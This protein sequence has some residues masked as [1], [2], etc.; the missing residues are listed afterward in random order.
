MNET[1]EE[2]YK[3]GSKA[4]YPQSLMMDMSRSYM[5]RQDRIN[6]LN[7]YIQKSSYNP[8][9][10]QD[11]EEEEDES[12][13]ETL[14]DIILRIL[15][16]IYPD[17][18]PGLWFII[19]FIMNLIVLCVSL[20]S[21]SEPNLHDPIAEP[22]YNRT[23]IYGSIYCSF[24]ILGVNIASFTLIMVIH[25]IIQK[26]FLEKLLQPSALCA[27]FYNTV[28]PELVYLLW[29][30]VQIIYWRSNMI[31]K[32]GV[33]ENEN[34]F[35]LR[36]FGYKDQDNPFIFLSSINWLI[37]FPTLLYIVF[38]ARLLFLSIISFVFEL[39]FLMNAHDLLGKYLS[40]YGI[41]RKFNIEWFM[42][43]ADKQENIRSLFGYELYQDEK[44]I[45]QL[46]TNDISKKFVQDKAE[47]LL[48]KNLP[49]NC[50]CCK[51]A[52]NRNKKKNAM[53]L[54]VPPIFETKNIVKTENSTIKNWL[55]CHYVVNTPP[56]IFLLNNSIPL[57]NKNSVKIAGDIL[58]RQIIM[59]LK[60][61]YQEKN[62]TYAFTGSAMHNMS[63]DEFSPNR[64]IMTLNLNR[65][66]N[67]TP[68]QGPFPFSPKNLVNNS[69]SES[70]AKKK[71]NLENIF[72][73]IDLDAIRLEAAQEEAAKRAVVA[74]R[75]ATAVPGISEP[76]PLG[77]TKSRA[78]QKPK[79]KRGSRNGS[80]VAQ[81]RRGKSGNLERAEEVNRGGSSPGRTDLGGQ[82]GDRGSRGLTSGGSSQK[83]EKRTSSAVSGTI[84]MNR[85]RK[86]KHRGE[87]LDGVVTSGASSRVQQIRSLKVTDGG[88]Q[89]HDPSDD[90]LDDERGGNVS[91]LRKETVRANLE[92]EA[93]NS[94]TGEGGAILPSSAIRRR[95]EIDEKPSLD[96]K[97][98]SILEG[99]KFNICITPSLSII[100]ERAGEKKDP[101]GCANDGANTMYEDLKGA[102]EGT[103][104]PPLENYN[105]MQ[106]QIK[107][108]TIE[109]VLQK[110]YTMDSM[111]K[112]EMGR[113]T[114][115]KGA[116]V[117]TEEV[118]DADEEGAPR[119]IELENATQRLNR[120]YTVGAPVQNAPAKRN[121]TLNISSDESNKDSYTRD[122]NSSYHLFGDRKKKTNNKIKESIKLSRKMKN[123][124]STN[125]NTQNYHSH[126]MNEEVNVLERSDAINVKILKENKKTKLFPCLC[127]KKNKKGR[128][129]RIKKDI[130]LEIDDPFV[131]NVRSPMQMSINGNEFITK[132]MIEVFLKPEEAEEF[133]KEFDLSGHGKID[134]LMFRN[135]IKRA[136]SCR[137]K[138]IKSLKGQESIL[139]L[140]RRLMSI[141]LSFLASVVLLFIFGVSVDT[142][143]VT[144]A[145]FIT[146][147]T[148][149]L[150]YMY[151]S[152]ITSVIFIAFSNPYN[153]GDRIRL[154][155]GEAMYIKKIK[156]YTTEFETTTGKIV[157]YENSKLSNAKIYNESRSKNAYIDISFKVDINTPLLALKELRKSLQFLVDSRPSDFCKTKNLYFGYSLQPGHFYEIS[158]W[159]KCVEGWGNW[160][161]V[162]ELRTDIYDFII[163][164]LRLLSISYRLP[165]QKVGFTAPLN[166]MDTS[167]LKGNRNKPYDYSSPPKEIRNPLFMQ[168][169]KH[170]RE[171]DLSSYELQNGDVQCGDRQSGEHLYEELPSRPQISLPIYGSN[172]RSALDDDTPS[173]FC[174][175]NGVDRH[176]LH[177]RQSGNTEHHGAGWAQDK[178]TYQE[179]TCTVATGLFLPKGRSPLANNFPYE[180][181]YTYGGV[182][183]TKGTNIGVGIPPVPFWNNFKTGHP[184]I[185]MK[186]PSNMWD[187]S[188]DKSSKQWPHEGRHDWKTAPCDDL[189]GVNTQCG[190]T[191]LYG[192]YNNE[193]PQYML[194]ENSIFHTS[195]PSQRMEYDEG[196]EYSYDS[197]SGYDSFEYVKHFTNLHDGV[198]RGA[199]VKDRR[200]FG[201]KRDY[202]KK[203]K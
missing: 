42:F 6:A 178:T 86:E 57:I 183:P 31:L 126:L 194:H 33:Q 196:E 50:T 75:K 71:I 195:E 165:T 20:S 49:R 169:A 156:T 8:Q 113:G 153:I 9:F 130:S 56:L 25:A 53:K 87:T 154:D 100:Q 173:H 133:M 1:R 104:Y 89:V 10:L 14:G 74:G 52:L 202:S 58:F 148:V 123:N 98:T 18:S 149:I 26:V 19:H 180:E 198:R 30:S 69:D 138:F 175:T 105:S 121:T 161:K 65:D 64:N 117:T 181:S 108:I 132:E 191:F 107:D 99:T 59:S 159:I 94:G 76:E 185:P 125:K 97:G 157:I 7:L 166:I 187:D 182:A 103:F 29:S 68:L 90:Q 116:L 167:N 11:D 177:R 66:S 164:Q 101:A 72:N 21:L 4:K 136:I 80:S 147:V 73:D 174:R 41:L 34:Y 134:M 142:I 78:K 51:I 2:N 140:V 45:R 112:C 190:T 114:S 82:P 115:E 63:S 12:E 96:R 61:Y 124:G 46:E 32:K 200:S 143:I 193:Q 27:A 37:T 23:F 88:M 106:V 176:L 84:E 77:K 70:R 92:R 39:G 184:V 91:A 171:F 93:R 160:R 110:K 197:S 155:G 172:L 131:M 145:A 192:E 13:S 109:D 15:S 152:F 201:L 150:S 128:F 67:L 28:D 168:S 83:A 162:F 144:G 151:T 120:E 24:L 38:A 158:F 81:R 85:E 79:A 188:E 40:K 139:K 47:L 22:K 62:D 137:K 163:L 60:M 102:E 17:L 199:S 119:D 48:F 179:R 203:D 16:I 5:N 95:D 54:L 44:M 36:I 122:V 111:H 118:D 127:F 3:S 43:M 189:D 141:L 170:K 146:A 35:V 186:N 55:A 129:S 135:A